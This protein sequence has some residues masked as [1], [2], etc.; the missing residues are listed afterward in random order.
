MD[1]TTTM[2]EEDKGQTYYDLTVKCDKLEKALK[3]SEALLD[4]AL[5][6]SELKS[7]DIAELAKELEETQEDLSGSFKEIATLEAHIEAM[8]PAS[9]QATQNHLRYLSARL[10]QAEA[11]L[12]SLALTVGGYHGAGGK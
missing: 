12:M 6:A 3:E 11:I 10:E 4:A 5:K 8:K 7:Q 2:S 9:D 1:G